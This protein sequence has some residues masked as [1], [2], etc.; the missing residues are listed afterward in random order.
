[1]Y[2]DDFPGGMVVT[3]KMP[4]SL[5]TQPYGLHQPELIQLV[6]ASNKL[7]SGGHIALA[8]S[9]AFSPPLL[10]RFH[11]GRSVRQLRCS[12]EAGAAGPCWLVLVEYEH[13]RKLKSERLKRN[14]AV[15]CSVVPTNTG[16]HLDSHHQT[17]QQSA[18]SY[19]DMILDYPEAEQQTTEPETQGQK[20]GAEDLKDGQ[21]SG[22]EKTV[23][24]AQEEDSNAVKMGHK[25][26]KT[27]RVQEVHKPARYK[28]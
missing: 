28:S 12:P 19:P 15:H 8:F 14:Q 22:Q 17:D 3:E 7:G 25:T 2:P 10:L 11:F 13:K 16:T 27:L 1:M 6:L 24:A 18:S 4:S 23:Q 9:L 20:Q 21:T 5:E 26:V